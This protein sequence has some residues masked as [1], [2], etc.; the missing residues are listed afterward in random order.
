MKKASALKKTPA[1]IRE[2]KLHAAKQ[3]LKLFFG[4]SSDGAGFLKGSF[5]EFDECDANQYYSAV[6]RVLGQPGGSWSLD[7]RICAHSTEEKWFKINGYD[8][9]DKAVKR[10]MFLIGRKGHAIDVDDIDRLFLKAEKQFEEDAEPD[11]SYACPMLRCYLN[12]KVIAID[13]SS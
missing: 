12:E 1:G 11:R 7:T 3:E 2:N 10:D 6:V 8:R 5:C 9:N 4:D 13:W